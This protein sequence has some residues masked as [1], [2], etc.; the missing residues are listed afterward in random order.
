MGIF[1]SLSYFLRVAVLGVCIMNPSFAEPLP[2]SPTTPPFKHMA[3]GSTEIQFSITGPKDWFLYQ[4]NEVSTGF[5]K[6]VAPLVTPFI[7]GVFSPYALTEEKLPLTPPPTI[8][9]S[10]RALHPSDIGNGTL[11]TLLGRI[12]EDIPNEA[13]IEKPHIISVNGTPWATATY[14]LKEKGVALEQQYLQTRYTILYKYQPGKLV[15]LEVVS[16]VPKKYYPEMRKYIDD[17][18]KTAKFGEDYLFP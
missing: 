9:V 15:I 1:Q 3:Y 14:E 12:Y 16:L 18:I 11:E 13:F 6:V 2:P 10:I 4:Q 8:A 5:P 7:R 17:M